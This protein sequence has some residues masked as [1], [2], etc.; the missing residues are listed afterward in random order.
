MSAGPIHSTS[1]TGLAT[2]V[3]G[4]SILS[5][6]LTDAAGDA[7]GLERRPRFSRRRLL[8]VAAAAAAAI[9]AAAA[10]PLLLLAGNEPG[11]E[12]A[13]PVAENTLL[14]IDPETGE[15]VAGIPLGEDPTNLAAGEGHPAAA[16]DMSFANLAL[17]VEHL[18]LH[19]DQLEHRVLD[20][21]QEL[22]EE[23]ARLKLESLGVQIVSAVSDAIR[24]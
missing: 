23:I 21:P 18:A 5:K 17:A 7:L 22:D 1:I 14:R 2:K 4:G 10:A 6:A 20:V 13:L 15:P 8:L 11:P 24:Q 3:A 12:V 19:G 9:A 16:M